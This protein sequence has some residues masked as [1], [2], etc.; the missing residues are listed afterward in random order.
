MN[1]KNNPTL[2]YSVD[3]VLKPYVDK[4]GDILV[5]EE[6]DP[7][8]IIYLNKFKSILNKF[9]LIKTDLKCPHC[10]CK[11]HVHDTVNFNLNNSIPMLKVVYRCS[12][13]DCKKKDHTYLG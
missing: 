11:L 5:S 3:Q 6:C 2:I 13:L 1:E 4:K 7:E 10:G 9:K 12:N 8:E